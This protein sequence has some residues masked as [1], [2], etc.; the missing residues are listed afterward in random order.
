[1]WKTILFDLDGTLTD[2]QEGIINAIS[3]ALDHFG[4]H[5]ERG[6]LMKFIG[7]P[8]MES[9]PEYCG[10]SREQSQ[11][12]I[13][14]FREYY[15][16][17]GWLENAPFPGVPELLRD[18]KAAGLQLMVATSKP[19]DMAVRV[20]EHFGLAQYFD[21]I[22]GAPRSAPDSARKADV[23][24]RALS[25][26]DPR[27]QVLSEDDRLTEAIMVGDRLHDVAGAHEAGLS[28][29]GVLYGY[30]GRE[31][32]EAAGAEFIA[33]DIG[34]LRGLLLFENELAG[35]WLQAFGI[36]RGVEPGVLYEHVYA[37]GNL[38]WHVF[39]WGGPPYLEGDEAR[40]AFDALNY[41]TAHIFRD[42]Y[43]REKGFDISEAGVTAKISSADLDKEQGDV[44]VTDKD[45]RWTYVRTHEDDLCG[46]YFCQLD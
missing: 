20:L 9:L 22:C 30:G 2:S 18:L 41:D 26:A 27:A 6:E 17:R 33:E 46:P 8:L 43:R 1:M 34:A 7:P 39:S 14:K 29:I 40:R 4:A 16:S 12:V 42:G 36:D 5:R 19:E 3:Y 25:W 35:R 13:E 28:C 37:P 15:Q 45:F 21:Q 44:Y 10:F 38:L 32:L 11:A 31:E 23:V 24:R